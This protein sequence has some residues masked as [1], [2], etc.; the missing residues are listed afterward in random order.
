MARVYE[1]ILLKSGAAGRYAVSVYEANRKRHRREEDWAENWGPVMNGFGAPPSSDPSAWAID[2]D[3]RYDWSCQTY[4]IGPSGKD[5]SPSCIHA[6]APD[7]K[8]GCRACWI[9]KNL[10]ITYTAH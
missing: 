9:S 1:Q 5:A 3:P 8:I 2:S 4:A 6:L 10:R 7:G